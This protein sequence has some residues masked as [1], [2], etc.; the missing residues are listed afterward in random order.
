MD[1]VVTQTAKVHDKAWKHMFDDFLKARAEAGGTEL[2]PFDATADYNT[3][4]DGKP[5]YDGVRSFLA[6]RNITLPEGNHDDPSSAETVCGLGNRKNEY[7]IDLMHKDGVEPYADAVA[8][9][10]NVRSQGLKTALVSS[11]ANAAEILEAAGASGLFDA[12][13][14]G[15]A[16]EDQGLAGKPAPDTYLYAAKLVGAA[17]DRSVVLE[18]AVSGV[19]AGR[20]GKFGLVVGVDRIGHADELKTNGADVATSDLTTLI[21]AG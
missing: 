4:V 17:P 15:H 11:S 9:A 18:D 8:L 19:E 13:V 5:R 20:A 3:Y 16:V 14:D 21:P 2:V 6:S 10:K 7:F 1:G 12:R